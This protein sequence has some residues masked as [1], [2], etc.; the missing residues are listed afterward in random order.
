MPRKAREISSSGIYHVITRGLNK[1]LIFHETYDYQQFL[2]ILSRTKEE[3]NFNLYAYCLMGNHVHLLIKDNNNKISMIMHRICLTYSMWYNKKY[4]RNGYLFQ[5]RFKSEPVE[6]EQYLLTV[7]RYIHQNPLKAGMV[8]WLY[9]YRW[10]SY[11]DYYNG[12]SD[13]VDLEMFQGFFA[14]KNELL[15][16]L[17]ASTREMCMEYYT[18]NNM[19]DD[20]VL[21][22][23]R[24]V[25]G[26][27]DPHDLK[28]M[29][30]VSIREILS[31]LY[32]AGVNANQIEKITGVS[33]RKTNKYSPRKIKK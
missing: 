24:T 6:N 3:Y 28:K 10:S 17:G 23:I 29:D 19:S 15:D 2:I 25:S 7:F 1:Q 13:L 4:N 27:D 21:T 11:C 30:D 26:L 9:S 31:E 8:S 32:K 22:I 20:D 33:S 14:G 16:F 12:H 5:N 18:R